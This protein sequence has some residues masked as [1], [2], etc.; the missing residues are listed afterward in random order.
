MAV[1]KEKLMALAKQLQA[2]Q[3]KSVNVGQQC[4]GGLAV[5]AEVSKWVDDD[6]DLDEITE[7]DMQDA[8]NWVMENGEDPDEVIDIEVS[9]PKVRAKIEAQ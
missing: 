5:L 8:Y 9:D 7:E 2:E 1:T 3:I 6:D 4:A